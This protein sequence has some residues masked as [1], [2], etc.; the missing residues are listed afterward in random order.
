MI[1]NAAIEEFTDK[2]FASAS[3]NT[4]VQ[5]LNISKG[6]LF[7]Y[8]NDKETLFRY[9][10]QIVLKDISTTFGDAS[11]PIPEDAKDRIMYMADTEFDILRAK[12][13]YYGFITKIASSPASSV[14]SRILQELTPKPREIFI[15][16][17]ENAIFP[18]HMV[19]EGLQI[20][21]HII[22][23]TLEGIKR[24]F[25]SQYAEILKKHG[26]LEEI[27]RVHKSALHETFDVLF[28]NKQEI[29]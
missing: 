11:Q 19:Q 6:S 15:K 7:Q 29:H 25:Q 8:F 21:L 5:N 4:V 23:Y 3:T 27:V 12:P 24:D 20:W 9:C 14:E 1:L 22:M 10:L 26:N 13:L 17:M 18:Q 28:S 2:G 16:M